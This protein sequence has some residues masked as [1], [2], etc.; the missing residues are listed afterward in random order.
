MENGIIVH[1]LTH[2]LSNRLTGGPANSNC[3][4]TAEAGGMGEGWSDV[5]SWILSAKADSTRYTDLLMGEWV[6]GGGRGIRAFPYSTNM[7]TNPMTYSYILRNQAVHY[8]GTIWSTILYEAYWNLVEAS[9]FTADYI[10]NAGGE[11]GNVRFFQMVV[12]GM[13]LQPCSPTFLT[14]RDAIL[15]ADRVNYGGQYRCMLWRAFAKRGLGLGAANRVDNYDM[16]PECVE[17]IPDPR[18]INV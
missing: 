18:P 9:G 14:A 15:T 12:D 13:K 8:I 6:L 5:V 11:A 7:T 3:L 10:Q 4:G 17:F 2:G 1:E 16:P